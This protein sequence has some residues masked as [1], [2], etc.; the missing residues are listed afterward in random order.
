M[1]NK[2]AISFGKNAGSLIN[3]EV[4]ENP[5]LSDGTTFLGTEYILWD[6]YG[7]KVFV[8]GARELVDIRV[9]F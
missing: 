1:G 7:K 4:I 8:E 3:L 6:L 9:R 5:K 2:G